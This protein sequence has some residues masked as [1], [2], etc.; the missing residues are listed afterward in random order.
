LTND[1]SSD[2]KVGYLLFWVLAGN[3]T[4]TGWVVDTKKNM[5]MTYEKG[6]NF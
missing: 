5:G 4:I 1:C 3:R 2:L 6:D